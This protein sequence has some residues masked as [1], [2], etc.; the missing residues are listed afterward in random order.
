MERVWSD[1]PWAIQVAQRFID[2]FKHLPRAL[3]LHVNVAAV[4]SGAGFNEAFIL[5]E[6]GLV[7]PFFGPEAVKIHHILERTIH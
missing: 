1:N 2:R 7:I 4:A 5:S 3:P 6:D